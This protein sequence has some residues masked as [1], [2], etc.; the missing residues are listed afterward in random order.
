MSPSTTTP[1]PPVRFVLLDFPAPHVLLVTINLEKQMNSLPVDAV[2][3]MHRVWKWFDDEPE[4]RVG[5]ITGAGKKAFS[6]GMDLKER[7]SMI[8]SD[9]ISASRQN[10]YPSTGFAGLTR[11]NGRK[12]I[13]AA[14]NGHA[15]G[16]GFEIIL[17]SD[18]VIASENAD[19]RLPD[20]I[21]G[22]AA[23][24]GAFPRLCR[25][26]GLQKAMWLGLTAHTLTAQEGLAWGLVQ[27]IVSID[28]L[29]K[30]AVNVAKLIASM[31]PDSVIVTRAGIRQAWETSSVEHATFLT[32]EAYAAD[33]MAGENAKE[34]ML[35]F[36]EKRLP[37]WV[38]SKL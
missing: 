1:P 31:S 37:K 33:L 9:S 15:H 5:I 36:K 29:V 17:N 27:K 18:I 28:D 14:C 19:F 38:P 32:G 20:V 25:T 10:S 8:A 35:A 26:F 24:A 6:A 11:R 34:G 2:W 7:Q 3:E 4:L 12:P 21:R 16:G 23:M 13:V 22:T 30:E